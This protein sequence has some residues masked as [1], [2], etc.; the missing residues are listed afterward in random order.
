MTDV[1]AE[2]A[3]LARLSY[4]SYLKRREEH[5]RI[6]NSLSVRAVCKLA[7]LFCFLWFVANYSYQEALLDTEAGIVNILSSTSGL[8]TLVLAA[9]WSSGPSD[10]FTLSKLIAVLIR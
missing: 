2:D 5:E 4:E 6:K 1:N 10:R 8:F 3:N 9:I 7:L